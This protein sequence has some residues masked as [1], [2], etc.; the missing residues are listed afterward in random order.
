[1]KI[2]DIFYIKTGQRIVEEEVYFHKGKFPCITS[3]TTNN[4]ITWYADEMW[5]KKEHGKSIINE[6]ECITWTKDGANCGTL[7]YRNYTFYPNDHCGVL[8]PKEQYKDQLSLKWFMYAYQE[9]IKNY[10]TQQGSQG[11]LYNEEM[12]EI[13]IE[14]PFPDKKLIQEKIVEQYEKIRL[15]KEKI[16]SILNRLDDILKYELVIDKYV[17]YPMEKIALMNKGSNRISEEMIYL[18]FDKDGI[19]VYSSATEHDGLMGKVS[20]NCFD[21]FDKKGS[22]NELTWTTNGYAGVVFFRDTEYLYSEKCGRIVIRKEYKDLVLPRYLMYILNQI[23]HKYK[24]SESNNGKL[25]II[26]MSNIPIQLPI[27]EKGNIDITIQNK[28]VG[29]YQKIDRMRAI[30]INTLNRLE[31][32]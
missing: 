20:V 14:Y 9:E 11:M 21:K 5:L 31:Q 16:Y 1:M 23:T 29:V 18:N 22:P 8:I 24:T 26:H 30:L 10:V 2:N 3:Q 7:F 19:P 17:E 12:G 25:D 32:I 13:E 27:N 15:L 6:K 28:I 4:G